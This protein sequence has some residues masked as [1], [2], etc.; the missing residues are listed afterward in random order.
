[1]SFRCVF[2]KTFTELTGWRSALLVIPVGTALMVGSV[3]LACTE[4]QASLQ[5]WTYFITSQFLLLS[6]FVLAGFFTAMLVSSTAA[7]FVAEEE[8]DGTLLVLASKP[9]RRRDVL[10]GKLVAL[11]IRTLLLDAI[12]LVLTVLV[13]SLVLHLDGTVLTSL[14]KAAF[15]LLVYSLLTTCFFGAM[16]TVLSTLTRNLVLIMVVMSLVVMFCFLVGPLVR[17]GAPAGGGFYMH[18]HLYYAD[19]SYHLQNAFVPFWALASGGEIIPQFSGWFGF[20]YIVTQPDGLNLEPVQTCGYVHPLA[21][22]TLVVSL[23]AIALLI[24]WQAFE[25][26]DIH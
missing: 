19:L 6:Y 25:R 23:T 8:N 21:S 15:W 24:A 20:R 22:M 4:Q 9:I 12:L 10:L 13:S 1:M 17:S 14:L 3:F 7:R 16:A 26:R 18:H 2:E 11:L 5:M